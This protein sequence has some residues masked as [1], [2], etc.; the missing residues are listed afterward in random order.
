MSV[1]ILAVDD[2]DVNLTILKLLLEEEFH[3]VTA[4]NGEE[5]LAAADEHEPAMILLDVNLPDIDGFE[6]CRRL[7]ANPQ[8]ATRKILFVSAKALSAERQ[9]GFD[10]GGD[11]YITKPF[12]HDELLAKVRAATSETA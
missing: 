8:H 5:T 2:N 11:D 1:T 7:R 10:A 4:T 9:A 3:V 12:N 6:V